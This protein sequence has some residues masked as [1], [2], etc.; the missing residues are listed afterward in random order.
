MNLLTAVLNGSAGIPALRDA[1]AAGRVRPACPAL[2][3]VTPAPMISQPWPARTPAGPWPSSARM[4]GDGPD[5][6]ESCRR[7]QEARWKRCPPG[8]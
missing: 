4:N 6:P 5:G 3:T 1:V 8:T 2:G 7:F